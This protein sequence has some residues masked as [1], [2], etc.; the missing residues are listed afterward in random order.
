MPTTINNLLYAAKLEISGKVK[1]GKKISSRNPG[2][3][4]VSMSPDEERNT[5]TLAKAPISMQKID[6]WIKRVPAMTLG[7][8][9]LTTTEMKR[10]SYHFDNKNITNDFT[11]KT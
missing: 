7:D 2:I 6:A 8:K 11:A 9:S 4:I 10:F 3:Y 1:W 5:I